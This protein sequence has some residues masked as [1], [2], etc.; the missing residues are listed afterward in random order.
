M[1]RKRG[2]VRVASASAQGGHH[3]RRRPGPLS[4]HGG[5]ADA[6]RTERRR[7]A[8][9]AALTARRDG[10]EEQRQRRQL[11]ERERDAARS[12]AC[13]RRPGRR[14]ADR[15][16]RSSAVASDGCEPRSGVDKRQSPACRTSPPKPSPTLDR[17]RGCSDH[18]TNAARPHLEGD[19]ERRPGRGSAANRSPPERTTLAASDV[20]DGRRHHRR[21]SCRLPSAAGAPTRVSATN[22]SRS[23]IGRASMVAPGNASCQRRLGGRRGLRLDEARGPAVDR[24]V[25]PRRRPLTPA[26]TRRRRARPRRAGSG[27]SSACIGS[28]TSSAPL[29]R[30]PT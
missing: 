3:D 23:D 18:S 9:R 8:S 6:P 5:G 28:S 14:T 17:L 21:S 11:A 16:G 27:A 13:A 26:S 7:P 4:G 15:P 22:T 24:E 30:K 29:A 12:D 2:N 20:A 1:P 19:H 10:D 25:E